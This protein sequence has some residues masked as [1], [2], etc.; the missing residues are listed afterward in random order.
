M[1]S[2]AQNTPKKDKAKQMTTA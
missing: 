2:N 1:S